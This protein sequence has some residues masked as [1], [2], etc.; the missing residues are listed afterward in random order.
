MKKLIHICMLPVLSILMLSACGSAA[1][2][3]AAASPEALA[4]GIN[5]SIQSADDSFVTFSTETYWGFTIDNVLHAGEAG[6]IHYNVYIPESYDGSE[7]YALFFTLPGYEGLYF[8]GVAANLQSE[9]FGFEAQKYHEDMIVVAPQLS[10]WRETS[11]NQTIALAEYFLKH[12]NIDPSRVYANG[13]SGGGETMSIV[14]GKRP[15]LFTAY[16]HCSSQWDGDLKVLAESRTPVYLVVGREDEYYGSGPSQKACDTLHQLYQEQG[17]TDEEISGLLVLDI[18]ERSYFTEK[19]LNNEHGGGNL[20]AADEDIMDWLFSKTKRTVLSGTIPAELEYIPEGY[21]TP[22]EH[23]GTLERLDYQT[24]E[25]LS[26]EDHTRQLTK[27]AWVYLPYGYTPDRKYNVMYLS[28]GG[29][30]NEAS[31]MGTSDDPHEFKHIMDHAIE[32]GKIQPLIIVLPTYNNTSESDSGNYSLSLRLTG[33]F[34]N[35]LVND[36]IPAVEF[37]YSTYAESTDLA[38]LTASRDHRGFGGFSMGSM[39]TWHT[40]EYCL[41]YFR[42]FAPSSGG[43]IGNGAYMAD[44]VNRS[45][46]SPED[47]FIFTASGTND[48]AYSGFKS[49]VTA[50]GETDVFTFADSEVEGNL[51]FREREGYSHDGNAANEYMYNALR[52][53]WN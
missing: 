28:H 46:Q 31:M 10:D 42:Y 19:G 50:M 45:S 7:P 21:T 35:E 1:Q 4:S 14:M 12:Y 51:S 47:F 30:S 11:A 33:N 41:D 53:F 16:L 25:S 5:H 52:F 6:D 9:E 44:I 3:I 34:H 8:Q 48:F 23:P 39:N 27:T 37:R 26:Y 32:D 49:G 18:K 13:Y 38:G 36:L 24:W 40:F 17:L 29:R 15:E 43:P 20:F 22:A 2:T